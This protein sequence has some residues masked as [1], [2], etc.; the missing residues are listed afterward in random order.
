MKKICTVLLMVTMLLMVTS[1]SAV[2][3]NEYNTVVAELNKLQSDYDSLI[4]KNTELTA[5]T[6][7][8][9][10]DMEEAQE[11]LVKCY[12]SYRYLMMAVTAESYSST[13]PGLSTAEWNYH[14]SKVNSDVPSAEK[15]SSLSGGKMDVGYP[16]ITMYNGTKC[17]YNPDLG[18]FEIIK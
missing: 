5:Q 11:T 10:K 15:V 3:Q 14:F 6:D 16:V 13:S 17:K 18:N 4:V 12:S 8:Q 9:I 1:C 7:K 2:S